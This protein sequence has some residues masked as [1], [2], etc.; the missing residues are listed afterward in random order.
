MKGSAVRG[1][2]NIVKAKR[3]VWTPTIDVYLAN[4]KNPVLGISDLGLVS[5]SG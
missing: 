2:K 1:E 3:V 5:D 4:G